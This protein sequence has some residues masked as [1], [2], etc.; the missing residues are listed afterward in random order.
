M[1]TAIAVA[2]FATWL[3]LGCILVH[4][5]LTSTSPYWKDLPGPPVEPQDTPTERSETAL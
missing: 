3:T 5:A 2:A 4:V 1:I